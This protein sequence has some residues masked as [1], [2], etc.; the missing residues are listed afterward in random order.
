MAS[1]TPSLSDQFSDPIKARE[2]GQIISTAGVCG[3]EL[4]KEKVSAFMKTVADMDEASRAMFQTGG[5]AQKIRMERMDDIEKIAACALQEK[6][7][8]KYGLTP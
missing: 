5:G 8:A 3:Y 6:M 7:A 4:D 2:I 1:A